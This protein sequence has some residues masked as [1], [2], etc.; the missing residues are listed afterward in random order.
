MSDKKWITMGLFFIIIGIILG[1]MA[2]HYLETI[3]VAAHH[4]ESFKVGTHYLLYN[5]IAALGVA[6]INHKFDFNTY[7]PFRFILGGTI[8][9]S[10]SIFLLVIL[11]TLGVENANFL[12]PITPLGGLC[13]I[14]GW[15]VLLFN[16]LR[17]YKP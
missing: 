3:G 5:G 4:I 2:A 15:S 8:L 9:F 12:G 11:P 1:A 16:V 6:G 13:M 10:G 17:T 7:T 14:L